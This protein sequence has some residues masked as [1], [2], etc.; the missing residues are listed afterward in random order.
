MLPTDHQEPDT[1]ASTA[2]RIRP[3]DSNASW[4]CLEVED[5]RN[6]QVT[7]STRRPLSYSYWRAA[8]WIVCSST[9]VYT[10]KRLM[11]VHGSHYPLRIAFRSA[12]ATLIVYIILLRVNF[13]SNKRLG[14]KI[15]GWG[16]RQ[17]DG[18][19]FLANKHCVSM[20]P[21]S[22]AAA[23]SFPML[24]EGMLHM[25]N[26]AVLIMLFPLVYTTESIVLFTCCCQSRSR[27]SISWETIISIAASGFVLYEEYR[28][29]VPGLVLGVGGILLMGVSRAFFI[30]E[31]ERVGSDSA[32][33]SRLKAYHGFV[34]M[35]LLF[36]L[37]FSGVAWYHCENGGSKSLG[38]RTVVLIL[39]NLGSIVGTLFSGTSLLAYSPISFADTTLQFA[40]T[41]ARGCVLLAPFATSLLGL[42]A[43]IFSNP[44]SSTSTVQ[45][46]A[47]LVSSLCL[48]GGENVHA[49]VLASVDGIHRSVK[50]LSEKGTEPP[51]GLSRFISTSA[52]SMLLLLFSLLIS[53]FSNYAIT[54]L[55]SGLPAN[56][57]TAFVPPHR[58]D[59]VVAM[60]QEN[61]ASVK[62]MLAAV[63]TTA[64]LSTLQPRIILYTKDPKQ[65]LHKLQVDTGA[66]IVE[67]L[68]NF[69]REGGTYL[70]HIVNKWDELAA[71][72]MFIQAHAHNTREIIP[73]IGSYLVN[74]T[75]MLSLGFTGV[76]CSCHDCS[77]RWDWEDKAGVIPALY[78]KIY[79]RA[80]DPDENILLSYKG[81]FVASARRIRGIDREIFRGL[82]HTVTSKEG[83][84][85]D[86]DASHHLTGVG[87]E[88]ESPSNPY[89]GF[90]LERIWGLLMQCG[91]DAQVAARCPSLLSGMGIDG[92]AD[93]CQCLDAPVI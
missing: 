52:I 9:A 5:A 43:S 23:I 73:R 16:L 10:T 19:E 56:F 69:G 90:T 68:D 64:L 2:S 70:W 7:G 79:S 21:A 41:P 12:A 46:L 15:R 84:S 93:D 28:L 35:T 91:T 76:T 29:M 77:D 83:W 66:D 78:E 74:E 1:T 37:L 75:G 65:D 13:G 48:F 81:Q 86:T 49:F 36:S 33:Q 92:K 71:Q 31:A 47:Y 82:L 89:F 80:C 14:T 85:H 61:A 32:V 39:V 40:H 50:G 3:D 87:S 72:T 38:K 45:T 20:L 55:S 54:S 58:F 11:V 8:C 34:M 26:L 57:D 44:V 51:G 17:P 88:E 67:R 27:K 59:I 4:P 25:P 63:K 60:Y 30:I 53:S 62:S 18:D 22:L 6:G 42:L 24:F